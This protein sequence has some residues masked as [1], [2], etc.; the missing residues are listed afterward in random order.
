M[1]WVARTRFSHS[2]CLSEMM[3][4]VS[5]PFLCSSRRGPP[6]G[7]GPS[8]NS[9]HAK[10]RRSV[11]FH[12]IYLN[13]ISA[14]SYWKFITIVEKWPQWLEISLKRK[15]LVW[16]NVIWIHPIALRNVTCFLADST[17]SSENIYTMMNPIGPGG[18]RPNVCWQ[19]S[20][21]MENGLVLC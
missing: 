18:N 6:G 2:F 11:Y 19:F 21:R 3:F 13:F 10:P 14:F 12:L 16:G 4:F 7:G 8:R 17:N 1:W 20:C 5:N 15:A 9:H